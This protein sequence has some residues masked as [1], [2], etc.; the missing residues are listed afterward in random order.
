[1]TF[2]DL[3]KNQNTADIKRTLARWR[4]YPPAF[5]TE[6]AQARKFGMPVNWQM[7][8]LLALRKYRRVSVRSGHGIGK[9]RL[10][11]WALWYA[12]ICWHKP[13]KAMKVPCTGPSGS[14]LEDVLWSEIGV[15][16]KQLHPFLRD[17]FTMQSDKL[18]HVENSETW[19]A[20][21]RT[22][23]K[24]NPDALAG[25]HGDPM[26]FLI[27]EG[28]GVPDE[29]FEVVQG[30]MSSRGAYAL[31]FGNPVRLSGYF[32]RVHN[33]KRRKK[34]KVWATFR[35]DCRDQLD[36]VEQSYPLILPDGK[37]EEIQVNG[38]VTPAFVEEVTEEY[39][40]SSPVFC[41]RVSGEFPDSETDSVVKREW[42]KKAAERLPRSFDNTHR[43]M[44]VDVAYTGADDSSFVIRHGPCIEEVDAWH[45]NDTIET[46]DRVV[47]RWKDLE[48][49]KKAPNYICIDA[50]GVGAGVYDQ[51][52]RELKG[53]DVIV[54]PVMVGEKAPNEGG[55]RARCA[56]MRDWLWWEVR[57][58]FKDG[59]PFYQVEDERSLE[60][61][62][63]E[64]CL[65]SYKQKDRTVVIE[66]KLEIRKRTG[67]SP[68]RA[69]A[70]GLTFFISWK[71]N[72]QA[73][74][75]QEAAKHKKKKHRD[76]HSA[77]NWRKI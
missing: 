40:L 56:L 55:R 65:P 4:D 27:D 60:L 48:K 7:D 10:M 47:G 45:G 59:A 35:V 36:T 46:A 15:V 41:A 21:L 38:R 57:L 74:K 73:D 39:G 76:G 51:V 72:R 50:N 52:R 42:T 6:G 32:Y 64:V 8:T 26:F 1:M 63:D 68:D 30:A 17:Q 43:V 19:F 77:N 5:V 3:D 70:L 23:R 58:F 12:M 14:N 25:F 31:M 20:R 16:H 29:V 13:G 66:K 34:S 61:M 53:L 28:S 67:H 9:T 54:L 75:K 2:T 71:Q 44:G 62:L 49:A 24:E 22:S 69:D 37:I 33:P 18:F 11:A